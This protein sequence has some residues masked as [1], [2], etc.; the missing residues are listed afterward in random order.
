[1]PD[2][3]SNMSNLELSQLAK[4]GDEIA[5]NH[6]QVAKFNQFVAIGETVVY[7]KSKIEGRVLLKTTD[8]AKLINPESKAVVSLET[9]GCVLLEKITPIPKGRDQEYD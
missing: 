4:Q 7:E 9:I 1:M 6:L 3:Y 5:F 8:K 2:K